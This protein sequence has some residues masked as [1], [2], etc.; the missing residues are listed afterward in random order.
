MKQKIRAG[1]GRVDKMQWF[2][3]R[4]EGVRR[5]GRWKLEV[6]RREEWIDYPHL[7]FSLVNQHVRFC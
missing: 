2:N 1:T 5:K 6:G 4:K 3:N 7:K